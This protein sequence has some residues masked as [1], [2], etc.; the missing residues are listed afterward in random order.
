MAL[1]PRLPTAALVLLIGACGAAARE[2]RGPDAPGCVLVQDGWGPAGQVPIRVER[3]VAGLE[4]PWGL[5]F[6]PGSDVLVTERPGRVRLLSRGALV[7]EPVVSIAVSEAGEGGLL[8]I[9]ADPAFAEN[10]RFYV[11]YTGSKGGT[12]V[13]RVVR[14]VL[15]PDGRSAREDKVVLDDLSA[16]RFH[17]G[18]RIRFGPDGM[19][20]VGTGDARNPPLAQDPASRNGKILRITPDGAAPADNPT[21]GSPVLVSG[22][23]NVE[24]FDWLDQKTLVV[25]D[26]GP[27]GELGRSGHDEL[28]IARAGA[29]LG[30][31]D[32]YGCEAKAGLVS[33]AISWVQAAP[34][35]GASV[36]RGDAIPAWK[37]SVLVGTLGSRHL[38]RVVLGDD[39]RVASHEVYLMGEPPAG[40]GRIRE[41]VQGPDG[42]LWIT[43]SN[44]DGR[45]TCPPE[46]DA[47][48]RV[49]ARSP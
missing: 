22:V 7:A 30:W 37:G 35:G 19:L 13:N 18:G 15:A 31:P 33:P 28:T 25:V 44:C 6:L 48:L 17:D 16:G 26:H 12:D 27:S 43:T 41:A 8:G 11:Y 2:A 9:A 1:L 23:R 29:N 39:G 42:A 21:P 3:V 32:I 4:V 45:G 38:H 46:K 24:A 47:I 49:V 10:R 34:P 14:F 40:L 20:Y 36:Y 5:A